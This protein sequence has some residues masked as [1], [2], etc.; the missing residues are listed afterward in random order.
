[1]RV[2]LR[3]HNICICT[4]DI[5]LICSNNDVLETVRVNIPF[6]HFKTIGKRCHRPAVGIHPVL[7]LRELSTLYSVYL[8]C[9]K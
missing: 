4:Y 9:H 6:H 7:F 3:A 1:M 2:C 5:I 8:L